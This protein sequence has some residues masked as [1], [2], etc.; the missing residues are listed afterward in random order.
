MRKNEGKNIPS[1]NIQVDLGQGEDLTQEK[2]VP[3]ID[4]HVE[5]LEATTEILTAE[6][7][8]TAEK[9]E[10]LDHHMPE[11]GDLL[12][13]EGKD[14]DPLTPEDQE[15]GMTEALLMK[16]GLIPDLPDQEKDLQKIVMKGTR[17]VR[18]NT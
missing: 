15:E 4:I 12:T 17:D 14:Q 10:G 13:E 2:E 1:L 18:R 9:G 5:D 11:E 3:M 16:G 7:G 6:E 8:I